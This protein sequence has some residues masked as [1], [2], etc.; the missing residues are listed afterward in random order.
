[1]ARISDTFNHGVGWEAAYGYSQAIRVGDTVYVSG[2]LSHDDQ[3]IVGENDIHRQCEVTF[4]HLDRVLAH[5][6]ATRRQ[7]IETTVILTNLRENFGPAAAAHSAYFGDH[8]PTSTTF[9]AV[10]LALPGQVVEIG[11]VVL[12]DL[13]R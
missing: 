3:G 10:E 6:G 4:A 13:P 11:A 1:M 7:I 2:Q 9:G 12:L 8:R 5:F